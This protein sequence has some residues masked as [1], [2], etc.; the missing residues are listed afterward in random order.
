MWRTR[1]RTLA[2]AALVLLSPLGDQKPYAA[3]DAGQV[4]QRQPP[5]LQSLR[6]VDFFNLFPNVGALV[7]WSDPND[8]GID[9]GLIGRCTGALIEPRVFLTAGHCV[10]QVAQAAP[11][12]ASFIHTFVTFSPNALDRSSWR[13]VASQVAH[14]SLPPCPPPEGCTFRGLDKGILDIGLA[15]LTEPVRGITP[16]R[17][18]GPNALDRVAPGNG[19]TV[20]PGYGD[21]DSLPGGGRRPI[22]EW[23]G[24]R[25]IKISPVRRVADDGWA[26]W[27]LPGV[28][29]FGDS[30]TPTFLYNS[31]R[32]R[33]GDEIV[34]V[35]SDGGDV[36]FSRDD[37]SRVDTQ[38]ARDWVRRTIAEHIRKH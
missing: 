26:S 10:A 13:P 33:A 14:P 18:A 31:A 11:N 20:L 37:R 27:S 28:V 24:W 5:D 6:M 30:G 23:D 32:N 34:A 7:I 15:F 38:S 25:R 36:C 12:S 22:S 9:V 4:G 29:C 3:Q 1:G 35:A 19:L 17:L 21:L 16:A 2:L 8:L